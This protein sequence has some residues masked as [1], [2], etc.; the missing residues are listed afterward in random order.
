MKNNLNII[1]NVKKLIG[2]FDKTDYQSKMLYNFMCARRDEGIDDDLVL[3]FLLTRELTK[4]N[5]GK[6]EF[7]R[8]MRDSRYN[9]IVQG[10]KTLTS[11]W[12]AKVEKQ[13]KS[14]I[15]YDVLNI[16][17]T[18]LNIES[19]R[20]M[21][22]KVSLWCRKHKNESRM[23]IRKYLEGHSTRCCSTYQINWHKPAI[24]YYFKVAGYMLFKV[25]ITGKSSTH[26]RFSKHKYLIEQV[27]REYTFAK[28][29]EAYIIEQEIKECN[30]EFL[31]EGP[32][33]L[34]SGNTE[35]YIKDILHLYI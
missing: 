24:L 29:S 21:E 20:K 17:E 25:G 1:H 33:I 13:A 10:R 12:K 30:K 2:K 5:I 28:G 27:I 19:L 31:Y 18:F 35:L 8:Y 6:V 7:Y 9:V 15:R 23:P 22:H 3:E 14:D 34:P 11:D 4:S 16:N 26:E 32:N